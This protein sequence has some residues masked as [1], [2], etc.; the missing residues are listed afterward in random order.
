MKLDEDSGSMKLNVIGKIRNIVDYPSENVEWE[1]IESEILINDEYVDGLEGI[2]EN[3]HLYI[4]FWLHKV[5]E[6]DRLTLK[7]HPR[8]DLTRPLKGVFS[9]RS[10][11]RPNPIGLTIVELIR[12]QGNKLVVRGLDAFNDTPVLDIKPVRIEELR[13]VGLVGNG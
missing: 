6:K 8:R 5:S 4:I 3:K 10:P 2:E 12:R 11:C 7:V 9:T 1:K 13:S